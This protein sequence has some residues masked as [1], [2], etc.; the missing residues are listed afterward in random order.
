V[1]PDSER[2]SHCVRFYLQKNRDFPAS[3]QPM[4]LLATD[5]LLPVR[6]G[7]ST[8]VLIMIL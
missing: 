1:S 2:F 7:D 8:A 3:H 4:E 5:P 6:I